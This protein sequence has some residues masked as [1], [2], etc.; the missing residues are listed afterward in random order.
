MKNSI[1]TELE[2]HIRDC[3]NEGRLTIENFDEWHNIA[4]NEDHYI[5]GYYQCSEWLKEH[6]IGE[7]EAASICDQYEI[8][9]FGETSNKYDNSE[10][11][12]NMLVYIYGE[13][14][15]HEIQDEI[16][17]ELEEEELL[18][19][20]K[21]SFDDITKMR[22]FE[23]GVTETATDENEY[24]ICDISIEGKTLVATHISIT[25]EEEKSEKIPSTS[26]ELDTCF[27]IDEHLE[28][29]YSEIIEKICNS[30]LYDL[31]D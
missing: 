14:V 27:D 2:A 8:D 23:I 30:S 20:L 24:I 11:T 9:N 1:Q 22:I 7:F 6:E 28:S 10:T 21:E 16:K 3:A 18:S 19:E 25:E 4:F 29:L 13:E 17:K 31:A 5:I 15:M 12:V 26:I